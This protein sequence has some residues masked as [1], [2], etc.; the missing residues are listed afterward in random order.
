MITVSERLSVVEYH[1][2]GTT[3]FTKLLATTLAT[4]IIGVVV[5]HLALH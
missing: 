1:V 5:A 3:W 4:A 2:K